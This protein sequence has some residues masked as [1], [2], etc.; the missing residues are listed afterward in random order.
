MEKEARRQAKAREREA[1]RAAKR[2]E[3]MRC[4]A[5]LFFCAWCHA[6]AALC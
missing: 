5:P 3:R 6:A 4:V 1:E 2:A